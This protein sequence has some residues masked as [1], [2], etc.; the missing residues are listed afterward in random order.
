MSGSGRIAKQWARFERAVVPR[1]AGADQRGGM[2]L[3]FYAGGFA[4]LTELMVM[5]D[6]GADATAADLVKMDEIQREY[7]EFHSRFAPRAG[8]QS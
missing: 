6:P 7:D 4:L 2:Q 5:L 8:S 1:E 3:A